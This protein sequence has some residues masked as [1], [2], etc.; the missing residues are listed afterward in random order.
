MTAAAFFARTAAANLRRGGQRVLVALLCIAFGVMSLVAMLL[1]SSS[2]ER[3]MLVA[4]QQLFGA[5]LTV[6]REQDDSFT[7]AQI[8]GLEALRAAGDIERL[9]LVAYSSS[10]AF[11]KPGSG[12]LHMVSAGLGIDPASYP[13]VGALTVGQPGNVGPATLLQEAG[14]VLV[15]RDLAAAHRLAPGDAILL[16]DLRYGAPLPAVVRGILYDTPNH[17]GG[18]IYYNAASAERLAGGPQVWNTALITAAAPSRVAETLAAAGWRAFQAEQ[19][20]KNEEA[21]RNLLTTAF[22][23]AGLLGLMVGGVGVANTMQV[24]LSRRRKEAAVWKAIG[25]RPLA[26]QA[27]FACEALLLGAAGSLLGGALGVLLARLL[28][29][30]FGRTTTLLIHWQFA[31][32]P[33]AAGVGV[34]LVTTLVFAQFAVVAASRVPPAALLRG[35]TPR[36]GQIPRAQAAALGLALAVPLWAAAALVMGSALAGFAALLAG[37][38]G[39]AVLGGLLSAAVWL[40]ARLL[41]LGR[42]PLADLGRRRLRRRG[43]GL[44]F[45]MVALFVGVASLALSAVVTQNAARVMDG[46]RV[47]LD[48]DNLMV[49]GPAAQE[50]AVRAAL[51]GAPVERLSF[52]YHVPLS[53]VE[54]EGQPAGEKPAPLLVA[55]ETP[56]GYTLRG[57]PWD[58]QPDGV[59]LYW[60]ARLAPSPLVGGTVRVTA[61]DGQAH[62]LRVAGTY[63]FAFMEANPNPALGLLAPLRLAGALGEPAAL[64]AALRVPPARLAAES[65]RLGQALPGATVINLAAYAARF[66]QSYQNLFYFALA[67]AG[68]A[69]LAGVLL[70]ANAVSLAML[71]RCYE[72]GVLKAVGYARRHLL[73]AL[74]VEYGLAAGIAAAAGL[75]AVRVFLALVSWGNPLAAQLLRMPPATSLA[76]GAACLGLTLLTV[77][78][79]TWQPLQASPASL[80]SDR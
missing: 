20:A 54:V 17:Q 21:M 59:Y 29:T 78:L 61:Q 8:A 46:R 26:L 77:L 2:L 40:A 57:A 13:L 37:L 6:D 70:L 80:L 10:L 32:L 16:T 58:S 25:Y 15:T 27:L 65:A 34:G 50:P 35:E 31:P 1:L 60:P 74:M 64:Q 56:A 62:T 42:L 23:G 51:A 24:L 7:P 11:Y 44:V 12:E 49:L 19:L 38:A 43:L 69:L 63:D 5:D 48:G 36:A 28:V 71:D 67:L 22:N 14:D 55:R 75:G 9:T 73:A 76:V 41:P 52:G 18:K 72:L 39:L 33:A 66:T 4:P 68:L 47:V 53:A 30:L 79:T 45:A 3:T